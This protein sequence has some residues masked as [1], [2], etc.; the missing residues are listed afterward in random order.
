LGRRGTFDFEEEASGQKP[1]A[2][3]P[4]RLVDGE[5]VMDPRLLVHRITF[6]DSVAATDV[7]GATQSWAAGNPPEQCWAE[8]LITRGEDTVKNGLDVSKLYA[9]IT[10]RYRSTVN[11]TRR[12]QDHLG[13]VFI[14]Q[15]VMIL[16]QRTARG[17]MELPCL[18]VGPNVNG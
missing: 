5:V 10:I 18:G 4:A 1:G 12:I 9:K 7:S 11:A 14:I 13:N 16:G 3:M 15:N 8:I 2:G 6:L 17:W